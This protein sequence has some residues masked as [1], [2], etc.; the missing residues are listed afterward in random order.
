LITVRS[1][2]A[3]AAFKGSEIGV[4]IPDDA[5][6]V[7]FL[8]AE[9]LPARH[10]ERETFIR[11]K[12]KK[13]MPFDVDEAQVAFKVIGPHSGGVVAGTDVVVALSPR[14]VIDEYVELM[15]KVGLHAGFVIPSTLATL[16]LLRPSEEEILFVKVAPG[17][18]TTSVF[19]NQRLRFYRR[20]SEMPIYEA[21]YPT[22]LYYQDKL[23]GS[24]IQRIVVCGYEDNGRGV[25]AELLEKFGIPVYQLEPKSVDDIFKPT[26]GAVG[27]MIQQ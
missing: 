14:P 1:A 22:M 13:T 6:R 11:W 18:I 24:G 20:V 19:R 4:V 27:L 5:S 25:I 21:V 17:S 3:Q 2:L 8:T 10:D 9:N 23:M 16:N 12:L 15:E 7:A 26:L